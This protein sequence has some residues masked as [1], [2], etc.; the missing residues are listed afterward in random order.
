LSD[1]ENDETEVEFLRKESGSVYRSNVAIG[2]K[3]KSEK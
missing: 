1:E 3:L 2:S